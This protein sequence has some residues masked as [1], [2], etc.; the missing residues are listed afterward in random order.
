MRTSKSSSERA[1][2]LSVG[3][4]GGGTAGLFAALAIKKRYPAMRVTLVESSAVPIIGVG[5]ATTTLMPPFLHGQLGLDVVKLFREVAPTFKLGIRFDWGAPE[6]YFF[7]YPFGDADPIS[8]Y[9]HEGHIGRQSLTSLLMSQGKSLIVR[10]STGG[11]RSYLPSTKFAYHLNNASFVRYLSDA[12]TEAG[13]ERVDMK[14]ETVELSADGASVEKIRSADG[15]ELSFDFFVDAS[16]F[17]SLLLE[18]ALESPFKSFASSLF[19]DRA[20]VAEVPQE[21]GRI[22][23][24]TTAETMDAGWCWRIPVRGEDH[25][26]Y[27]HSSAYL[28]EDRALEEMRAKNPGMSEPWVV[29][30]RSG[31][32]A[33]FWKGNVVS[34]GNAYAFVEPLESTALHMTIIQIGYILAGLDVWQTRSEGVESFRTTVNEAVGAHWDYLRWFLAAHYKFN[35]RLDTPFWRE[36]RE[37]VDVSGIEGVLERFKVAGAEESSSLPY[38]DTGD[39]AFGFSGMMMIL[40]GQHAPGA[41]S[42]ATKVTSGAWNTR[43]LEWESLAKRALSHADALAVLDERP[44]FLREFM[45]SNASWCH[46]QSERVAIDPR[47]FRMVRPESGMP[48]VDRQTARLFRQ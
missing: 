29:K 18:G 43:V 16:G 11:H 41:K 26:G 33:E 3:I 15:R 19:C 6:D 21:R 30:F 42:A 12:A 17:R 13:I 35:R 14:I 1:P 34:V 2:V 39:P 22:R 45:E 10:E 20:I 31:R 25:R 4:I 48:D 5:E 27:V 46:A 23:P 36:A 7:N 38:F 40:L 47:A 37:S 24:Y 32:H 9:A 44:D 28:D 8:A